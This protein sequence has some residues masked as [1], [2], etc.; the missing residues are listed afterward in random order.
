VYDRDVDLA[1]RQA[2]IT[3]V[4]PLTEEQVRVAV[5]ESGYSLAG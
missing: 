1:S 5:E 2:R 4:Q 3:S